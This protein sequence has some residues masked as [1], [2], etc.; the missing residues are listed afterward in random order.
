MNHLA[1]TVGE[2]TFKISA[3][4][5]NWVMVCFI[6]PIIFVVIGNKFKKADPTKLLSKPMI[7]VEN[8]VQFILGVLES[9]LGKYSKKFVPI[10]GTIIVV[11][12]VSN[13]LG[14][15]GLQPPTTN[16]WINAVIGIT[17][18]FMIQVAAFKTNGFIGRLKMLAEPY[19]FLLPLNILGELALPISLSV[20]LFGNILS[21]SIIML[22]IY[23][24]MSY[25]GFFG[26]LGYAFTPVLHIYFDV[27][28][29]FIQG[30]VFMILGSFFLGQNLELE[31]E[32]ENV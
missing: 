32:K 5:L 12:I 4:A 18:F 26:I 13:L 3:P 29:G 9:N 23:S 1:I 31:E 7:V 15:I 27:F 10:Y 16:V 11:M 20:R 14:L 28:S 6:F 17:Y 8:I 24:L 30:Y 21:G 22:M 2:Y 25:L 19:P